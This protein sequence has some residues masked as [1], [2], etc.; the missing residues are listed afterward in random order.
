M[1]RTLLFD[2]CC[3]NDLCMW[4]HRTQHEANNGGRVR[5]AVSSNLGLDVHLRHGVYAVE[6]SIC[7]DVTLADE[8]AGGHGAKSG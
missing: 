7:A 5:M 6:D 8:Y 1:W 2:L 4:K 3:D